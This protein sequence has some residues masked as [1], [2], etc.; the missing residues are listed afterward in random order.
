MDGEH[1]IVLTETVVLPTGCT[2]H[3]PE[4]YSF[5][6]FV[7]WV[8]IGW[9]V[10]TIMRHERLSRAGN[11][12]YYVPKFK[13][14]QYKWDTREEALEWALKVVDAKKV[15]GRTFEQWEEFRSER[16]ASQVREHPASGTLDGGR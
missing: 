6:V 11:W 2:I 7:R 5:A 15:N 10:T 9:A 14:H 13:R 3:D 8:G 4:W 16:R 1:E 12:S